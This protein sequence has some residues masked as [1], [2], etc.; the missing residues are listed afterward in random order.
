M[1]AK[2]SAEFT[3]VQLDL[4]IDCIH[5]RFMAVSDGVEP[6]PP[7]SKARLL[8]EL[9]RLHAVVQFAAERA[10]ATRRSR[11]QA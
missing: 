11:G 3:S 8:D 2:T 10:A 5:D 4:L 1:E 9:S 6:H 7:T